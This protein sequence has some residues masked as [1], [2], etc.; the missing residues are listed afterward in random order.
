MTSVG[1]STKAGEA[2]EDT[3]TLAATAGGDGGIIIIDGPF[4]LPFCV[5]IPI[6]CI[7]PDC[8]DDCQDAYDDAIE[9]AEEQRDLDTANEDARHTGVLNQLQNT[10]TGAMTTAQNNYNTEIYNADVNHHNQTQLC[11]AG[12]VAGS[13]VCLLSAFF[14]FGVAAVPCSIAVAAAVATCV[15]DAL[16][17]YYTAT[18]TAQTNYSTA[19]NTAQGAYDTGV[20]NENQQN[21]TNMQVIANNFQAAVDSAQSDLEDC[22]GD[23]PYII[24]DWIFFCFF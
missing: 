2:Q 13:A 7:D 9:D 18:N 20:A 21:I 14:S 17:D 10:L 12:G 6:F 3:E 22:L 4:P 15:G 5:P 16:S 23:C 1:V 19:V 11:Y 24:C 8:A